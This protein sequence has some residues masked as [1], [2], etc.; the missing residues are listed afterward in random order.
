MH[1]NKKNFVEGVDLI[2]SRWT[3]LQLS[4]QMDWGGHDTAGKAEGF[5]ESLVEYFEREGKTLE[6]EYVEDAL[7]ETM[8]TEFGVVLED[9]SE[10]EVAK[11]LWTLYGQSIIGQTELL[12]SLRQRQRPNNLALES[13]GTIIES[14]SDSS[15]SDE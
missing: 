14:S 1:P 4:I 3:A 7:L 13:Q 10:R 2:F 8:A 12:E 15:E 9:Q 5:K 6:P 11:A